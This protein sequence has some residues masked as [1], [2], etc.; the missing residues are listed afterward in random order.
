MGPLGLSTEKD[1][2]RSPKIGL[3]PMLTLENL[4]TEDSIDLYDFTEDKDSL[5]C[6]QSQRRKSATLGRVGL[7]TECPFKEHHS[8]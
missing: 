6:L 5:L 4:N 2:I 7:E 1:L 8:R 3:D